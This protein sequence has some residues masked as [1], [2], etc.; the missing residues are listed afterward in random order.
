[1]SVATTMGYTGILMAPSVI[2]FVAERTGFTPVFL[3]M[4]ALIFM[5]FLMSGLARTGDYRHPNAE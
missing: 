5:V 2:G 3:G 4:A 1:M